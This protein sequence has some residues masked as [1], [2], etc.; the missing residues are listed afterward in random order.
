MVLLY[1]AP[2]VH[3]YFCRLAYLHHVNNCTQKAYFWKYEKMRGNAF[4]QRSWNPW[5]LNSKYSKNINDCTSLFFTVLNTFR[6]IISQNNCGASAKDLIKQYILNHELEEKTVEEQKD[7]WE[8]S[9]ILGC[10]VLS[11][12]PGSIPGVRLGLCNAPAPG[13]SPRVPSATAPSKLYIKILF[14]KKNSKSFIPSQ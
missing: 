13:W 1:A 12:L 6:V 5:E 9:L 11:V 3:W 2:R 10:L 4:S 7:E 8:Y 14:P